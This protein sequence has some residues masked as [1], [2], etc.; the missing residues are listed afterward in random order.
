MVTVLVTNNSAVKKY[1]KFEIHLDL[2]NVGIE[3]PYDPKDID[4]SALFLSPS[5]K[6]II[7]NGFYDNY[8]DANQWK[9]RFSPN[10]TGTYNYLVFVNDAGGNG[11]TA[12]AKFTAVESAHHG[13]IKPAVKNPRY[14]MHDDGTSF[15]GIG[16]YSPWGNSVRTF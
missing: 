8:N 3:N 5:G 10:E 11:E 4:V 13:W 1:E 14:F 6:K 2:K 9:I 12:P 7:M 16:V 15:Y